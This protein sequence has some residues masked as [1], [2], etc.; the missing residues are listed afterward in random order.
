M[1]DSFFYVA[2]HRILEHEG[3]YTNN[4]NDAGNWTG[5]V[6]GKGINKGTK[7]GISAGSYPNVDIKNLTIDEASEIYYQDYWLKN[8]LDQL[9]PALGFQILDAA[10]QHGS[11]NAIKFLQK[12]LGTTPD[13][14]IGNQTLS[15]AKNYDQTKL[16]ILYIKERLSFYTSLS[17]NNWT[18]FGLGW[19][20][21]MATNI[22]YLAEDLDE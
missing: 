10:I 15:K 12:V 2:I 17:R 19:M 13:G 8:K 16:A 3:G 22:E 20:R 5:G 1:A 9:S 18:N 7:Y 4:P 21:R 6:V 14:I 11:R